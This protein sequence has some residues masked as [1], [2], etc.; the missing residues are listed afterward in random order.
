MVSDVKQIKELE[1]ESR[2]LKLIYAV[3]SIQNESLKNAI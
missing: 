3:L 1:Y 2:R